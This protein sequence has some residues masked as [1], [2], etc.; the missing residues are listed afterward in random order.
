MIDCGF[1]FII[2]ILC[3]WLIL[4]LYAP[5]NNENDELLELQNRQLQLQIIQSKLQLVYK[6]RELLS[7][8]PNGCT[9]EETYKLLYNASKIFWIMN[10][11]RR[12][13]IFIM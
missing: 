13:M 11:S 4:M 6:Y 8:C 10:S 5:S 7:L 9:Y 3:V 1:F 2:G 12:G